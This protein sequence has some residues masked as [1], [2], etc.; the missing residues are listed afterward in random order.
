MTSATCLTP[1]RFVYLSM[2]VSFRHKGLKRL[3]ERGDISRLQQELVRRIETRLTR[4]DAAT[5]IKDINAPG[6]DLHALSGGLKGF[7]AIKVSGNWRIIFRFDA[8]DIYD[9]DLIDYH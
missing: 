5:E 8:G 9:V 1:F 4:L 6:Y 3:Y 2:I 7:W